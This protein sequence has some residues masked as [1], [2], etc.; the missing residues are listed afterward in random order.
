M[1]QFKDL[2]I[3]YQLTQQSHQQQ[4]NDNV[5]CISLLVKIQEQTEN[6]DLHK[7]QKREMRMLEMQ[8]P[9]GLAVNEI[10]RKSNIRIG[11]IKGKWGS[12]TIIDQIQ[13]HLRLQLEEIFSSF[14]QN[15]KHE[16]LLVLDLW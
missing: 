1:P 15:R 11:Q 16:A 3:P 10:L 7:L 9:W 2:A 12:H 6:N 4:N 8:S 14:L 5:V 13:H